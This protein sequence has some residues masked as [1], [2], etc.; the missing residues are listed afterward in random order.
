MDEGNRLVMA[1]E[2]INENIR[3]EEDCV[4]HDL[5]PVP[6]GPSCLEVKKFYADLPDPASLP[7]YDL[8]PAVA[9]SLRDDL[10]EESAD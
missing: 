2:K 1:P 8:N 4:R 9:K 3:V 10:L 5:A 6:F 7:Q